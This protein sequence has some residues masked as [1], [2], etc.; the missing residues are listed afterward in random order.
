MAGI[1]IAKRGLGL[2]G[3]RLKQINKEIKKSKNPK[4]TTE[5]YIDEVEKI[6]KKMGH[7][8]P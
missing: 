6:N 3:K 4:A 7:T 1:G 5:K 8:G 2:L